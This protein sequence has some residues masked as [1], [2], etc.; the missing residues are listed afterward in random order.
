MLPK[1]KTASDVASTYGLGIETG[2]TAC[3]RTYGHGGNFF[4][5][6]NGTLSTANGKRQA[7]VMVNADES[8]VS[9]PQIVRT[10]E[11]ALCRG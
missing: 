5:W 4:A 3:G 11:T 10:A 2:V 7:V 8:G 9:W 1:P 6:R